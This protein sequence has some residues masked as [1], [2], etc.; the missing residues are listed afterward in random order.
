LI[1]K[2]SKQQFVSSLVIVSNES[3]GNANLAKLREGLFPTPVLV[4][5]DTY[6][7]YKSQKSQQEAIIL[8]RERG[9]KQP[10]CHL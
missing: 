7:N 5:F 2:K 8:A 1:E 10:G 3:F 6:E 9:P 4:Y